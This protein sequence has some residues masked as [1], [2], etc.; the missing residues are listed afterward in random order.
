[1]IKSLMYM[2]HIRFSSML[3]WNMLRY[4]NCQNSMQGIHP[5]SDVQNLMHDA[6]QPDGLMQNLMHDD[7]ASRKN[8]PMHSSDQLND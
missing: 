5:C 6:R 2:M 3:W 8:S 1:M 4:K 7:D